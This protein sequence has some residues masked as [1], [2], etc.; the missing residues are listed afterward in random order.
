MGDPIR[1]VIVDDQ[2]VVRSGLSAF[3]LVY[4]DLELV[5][6]AR[7]GDEA[8]TLCANLQ[9]DVVL[10]DLVMPR[11]DG[12]EATRAVREVCPDVAV[13]VLTSFPEDD[14]VR[15]ALEAGATSYLLKTSSS[16]ELAHA[17]R[18]AHAGRSI[19]A[20]EAA[21]VLIR[22][23]TQPNP[24][25]YD[26]TDREREVLQLLAQGL[27]NNDIADKLVI[28][29]TTAKFHVSNILSKLGAETRA[30]AVALA[31]QHNLLK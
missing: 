6:E 20:P 28:S 5:G 13:V 11:V 4:D 15:R 7:D 14:L 3:L 19:L 29:P 17:I 8:R 30:E 2:P 12:V 25:G 16:D 24:L 21:K 18:E 1:I 9:P 23:A 26:L 22:V 10:M 31:Y 27:S